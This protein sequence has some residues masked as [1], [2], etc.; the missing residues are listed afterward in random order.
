MLRSSI[1]YL[2]SLFIHESRHLWQYSEGKNYY[3]D[4][5]E[6]DAYKFVNGILDKL[7]KS[8]DEVAKG[9]E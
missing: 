3:G 2:S 9:S 7:V 6:K 8:K 1:S 5:A 4:K